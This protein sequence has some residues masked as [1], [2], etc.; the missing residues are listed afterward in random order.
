MFAGVVLHVLRYH[1]KQ[2]VNEGRYLVRLTWH[3]VNSDCYENLNGNKTFEIL[4]VVLNYNAGSKW[5]LLC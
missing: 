1:N 3:S 2:V 4:A 5:A